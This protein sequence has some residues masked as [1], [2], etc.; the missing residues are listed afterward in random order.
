MFVRLSVHYFLRLDELASSLS[1]CQSLNFLFSVGGI[2]FARVQ[3]CNILVKV[4]CNLFY[5]LGM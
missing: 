2:M 4:L 3:F 5:F 1:S